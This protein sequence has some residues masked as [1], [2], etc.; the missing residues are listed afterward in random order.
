MRAQAAARWPRPAP[1]WP[2]WSPQ[3]PRRR[4]APVREALAR[5]HLGRA[6]TV[7]RKGGWPCGRSPFRAYVLV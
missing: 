3:A 2:S 1:K 6:R 7:R 5:S 4:R